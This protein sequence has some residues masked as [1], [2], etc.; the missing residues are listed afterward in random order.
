MLMDLYI[1]HQFFHFTKD[2]AASNPCI[3]TITNFYI[4]MFFILK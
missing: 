2:N 4:T 3:L 1:H